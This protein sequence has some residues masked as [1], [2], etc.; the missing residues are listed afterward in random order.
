ML[1]W[2]TICIQYHVRNVK[3]LDECLASIGSLFIT[4]SGDSNCI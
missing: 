2:G 1:A 3:F 4:R